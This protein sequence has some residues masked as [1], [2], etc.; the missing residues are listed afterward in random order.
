MTIREKLTRELAQA[1]E[2][3]LQEVLSFVM[4]IKNQSLDTHE[5]DSE[6]SKQSVL[7]RMGGMPQ[8]LLSDGNLSDRDKR[9]AAIAERIRARHLHRQ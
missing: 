7:E 3:L 6:P 1:P 8:H 9:R 4:S 5:R 2:Y